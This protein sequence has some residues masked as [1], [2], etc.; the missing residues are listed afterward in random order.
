MKLILS[1]YIFVL[2]ISIGSFLNVVVYRLPRKINMVK[3]RSYCPNCLHKLSALD[4]FPLFSYLFLKAKCRY[5]SNKI[6]PT[7]FLIE[8]LTGVIYLSIYLVFGLTL[9][10]ITLI[11]IFTLLIPAFRIDDEN[12]FIPN[13]FPILIGM[14]CFYQS[15]VVLQ[16]SIYKTIMTAVVITLPYLLS[17]MIAKRAGFK[18]FGLGDIKLMF[19]LAMGIRFEMIYYYIYLTMAILCSKIVLELFVKKKQVNEFPFSRY[20]VLSYLLIVFFEKI[21]IG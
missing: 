10:S 9:Y 21:I 1:V 18:K 3:G 4:L 8:L 5:C 20:I 13:I 14:L 11:A 17:S 6:A 12:K 15:V 19:A 7:Y 2:G 16:E